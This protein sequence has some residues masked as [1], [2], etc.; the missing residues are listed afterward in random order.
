VL[1][2]VWCNVGFVCL[3]NRA[4]QD[5]DGLHGTA[6]LPQEADV[7]CRQP[8]PKGDARRHGPSVPLRQQLSRR[9]V[10]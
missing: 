6:R 7:D 2:D 8:S 1:C 10:W 9:G 4:D 3:C 5:V